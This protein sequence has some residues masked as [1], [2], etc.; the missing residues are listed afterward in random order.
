MSTNEDKVSLLFEMSIPN[1][2][3]E[4]QD[5]PKLLLKAL[6]KKY[7]CKCY[8]K[9][10]IFHLIIEQFP[11]RRKHPFLT[12]SLDIQASVDP[13]VA[14]SHFSGYTIAQSHGIAWIQFNNKYL[15]F[16]VRSMHDRATTCIHSQLHF[17]FYRGQFLTFPFSSQTCF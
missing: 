1:E 4:Q 14:H 16:M 12:Y 6:N 7:A 10:F 13:N 9:P 2:S 5:Q 15:S 17:H 11:F 8:K 3:M